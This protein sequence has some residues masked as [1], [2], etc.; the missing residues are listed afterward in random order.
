MSAAPL[1]ER[2]DEAPDVLTERRGPILVITI[3][4]PA[5]KNAMTLAGARIIAAALDELDAVPDLAAAV[6]TGS[7]GIFCAGMD[8]KRFAAGERPA[9][10]GR[11]FGGLVQAPPRKPLIAAVDGWALG[12][13]FELVLACDLVVAS[14]GARF[15]LPE[16]K[17]GLVARGGGLLRLPKILPRAVAMELLLTGDP[18]DAVRAERLGLVNEVVPAGPA[19]DRALDLAAR[20]ARN[21][22]LAVAHSKAVAAMAQTWT[23]DEGWAR[24]SPYTD[25]VFASPDASEGAQAFTERRDPVWSV[26]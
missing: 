24:Q 2:A 3:D 11:G 20:V 8:L 18:I 14:A 9:V 13:G 15:G 26:R 6:L 21:A 25:E 19:L 7:G 17:R 16:V 23:E 1:P 10:P 12:G 4:R 22:P 5:Q